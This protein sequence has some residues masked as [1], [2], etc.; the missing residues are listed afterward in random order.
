MTSSAVGAVSSAAR[1]R[2]GATAG[3]VGVAAAVLALLLAAMDAT[4][5][6]TVLPDVLADVGGGAGGGYAWL[7]SG[8]M[9]AQVAG[10]PL[11]GWIAD[12]LDDRVLAVG[13]TLAFLAASAAAGFAGSFGV[14]VA[15]RVVHGLAAGAIVVSSYVI[16]GRLYGPERRAAA[17]GMLSMVWGVA[18]VLGPVVGAA[19][20]GAWGWRW[21]FF[22]NVPLCV[23]VMLA[24]AV[25]LPGRSA[26]APAPSKGFPAR[27]YALVTGGSVLLLAGLQGSSLGLGAVGGTAAAVV[28]LGVLALL[29]RFGGALVPRQVFARTP[30][31][32]AALATVGACVVMYATVTVLPVRLAAQ[33]ASTTKVAVIVGVSAVGWV[34]GSA[35]TGGMV[36][37][38]GY[39][40]PMLAGS[41]VLLASTVC[42]ATGAL[43]WLA[44]ATAGL[45]TGAVTAATLALLQDQAPAEQ[46]G[47]ATSAATMVRNIG[48]AVGVNG[49]AALTAVLATSSHAGNGAFWALTVLVALLV[50][51]PALTAP[52]ERT[53]TT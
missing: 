46:L 33:G 28:G 26:D 2:A 11:A 6:G 41:L 42:S 14:L 16:V 48:S 13:A 38:R 31:A 39:R 1:P 21:V 10:T 35:V 36:A 34:L 9:L 17:Q 52:R 53:T 40:P 51:A 12:R 24:V 43:P 19:I 30:S 4:V 44:G 8:F 49:I 45:G 25:A 18:A 27:E 3:R 22:V 29:R 7:V 23:V 15:A 47:V 37:K 50:L 32:G 5:M 20:T